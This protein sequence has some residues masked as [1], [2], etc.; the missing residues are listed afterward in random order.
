ML[1]LN[2]F[3]ASVFLFNVVITLCLRSG[4]GEEQIL[5]WFCRH[6]ARSQM[7]LQNNEYVQ[8]LH[9]YQT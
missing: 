4:W 5:F 1:Q 9:S 2:I 7:F 8:G 6:T 3:W